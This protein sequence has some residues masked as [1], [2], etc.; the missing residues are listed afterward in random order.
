VRVLAPESLATR[1]RDAA[2]AALESYRAAARSG[3]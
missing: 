1:V 2:A 3:S